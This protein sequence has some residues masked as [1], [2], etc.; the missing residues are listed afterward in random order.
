MGNLVLQKIVLTRAALI[1]ESKLP[2]CLNC[3]F[4]ADVVLAILA[5]MTTS[6]VSVTATQAFL[7]ATHTQTPVMKFKVRVFGGIS[8]AL[9]VVFTFNDFLFSFLSSMVMK[10]AVRKVQ[11]LAKAAPKSLSTSNE[12]SRSI[13]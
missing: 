9:V 2:R 13:F 5:I 1:D 3:L 6:Y 4:C 8:I 10:G 7:V 12:L 11:Q